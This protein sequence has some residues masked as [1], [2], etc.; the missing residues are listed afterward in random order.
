[1]YI[2]FTYPFSYEECTQY[3]DQVQ[4]KVDN[5]MRD[6]VYIHREL[7]TLSLEARHVELITI[8]GHN[9]KQEELEETLPGLFP[10]YD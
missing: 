7:L 10:D 9:D 5:Q 1:M 6:S 2:A 8:S 3:F 4:A